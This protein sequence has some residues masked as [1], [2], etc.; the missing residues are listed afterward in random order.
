MIPESNHPRPL[1]SAVRPLGWSLLVG[2]LALSLLAD[3]L[4]GVGALA[5]SLQ[6]QGFPA[7]T[8]CVAGCLLL[9][10][11]SFQSRES[12]VAAPGSNS[13]SSGPPA[14]APSMPGTLNLRELE[15]RLIADLDR[16]HEDLRQ[17]LHEVSLLLEANFQAAAPRSI[18]LP[19]A[20]GAELTAHQLRPAPRGPGSRS[21]TPAFANESEDEELEILVEFEENAPDESLL[22]AQGV[23][24]EE[25]S[26]LE[27][28]LTGEAVQGA[29]TFD[30]DIPVPHPRADPSLPTDADSPY[31]LTIEP[32][33]A[34]EEEPELN[35]DDI[36]WLEWDEDDLV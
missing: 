16:K 30:W 13:A 22:W 36:R 5:E 19:L 9:A 25:S 17:E 21:Y 4:S 8:L 26:G 12:K 31:P 3:T 6:N 14:E 35:R 2:G 20:A 18:E 33:E 11:G 23:E 10:L 15:D 28:R 24:Q 1:P 29:E 7:G 32:E 27:Q 34:A